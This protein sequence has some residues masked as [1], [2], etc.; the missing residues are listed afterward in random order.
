MFFDA[1]YR[2]HLVWDEAHDCLLISSFT[3]QRQKAIFDK[4]I[5]YGVLL[6]GYDVLK[7]K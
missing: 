6:V 5:V 2:T 7:E 1:P 3:L 4:E